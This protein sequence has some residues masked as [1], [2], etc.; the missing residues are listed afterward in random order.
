MVSSRFEDTTGNPDT[1]CRCLPM[2]RAAQGYTYAGGNPTSNKQKGICN[3]CDDCR[4]SWPK[5]DVR[6]RDSPEAMFRC[7]PAEPAV[8]LSYGPECTNKYDMLCGADCHQCRESWPIDDPRKWLSDQAYCR[9]REDQIREV[10]FSQDSC[11]TLDSGLCGTH[12]REGCLMS[13]EALDTL[14]AGGPTAACR[15]KRSW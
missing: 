12:C 10:V 1:A 15:C 3:G 6:R 13:W 11:P 2:Q 5:D 8:Q 7:K 9:C 14:G 4:M